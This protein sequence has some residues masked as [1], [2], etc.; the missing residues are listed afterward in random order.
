MKAY[1]LLAKEENWTTEWYSRDKNGNPCIL[2][3]AGEPTCWC[4]SGALMQC[5]EDREFSIARN[6]L[7][8]WLDEHKHHNNIAFWNDHQATHAEVV[9]VLKELDL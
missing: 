9:R 6:K 8:A 1:E 4:T 2:E 3:D 5:Y 7:I